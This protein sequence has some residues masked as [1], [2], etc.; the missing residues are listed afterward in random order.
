MTAADGREFDLSLS[1]GRSVVYDITLTVRPGMAVWPQD[2][3]FALQPTLRIDQGGS[4]NVSRLTLS[5]HTGTH[6]DAFL[7]VTDTGSDMASMAL[8]AY[9]GPARVLDTPGDGPI[10]AVRLNT[11]FWEGAERLLFRTRPQGQPAD[12]YAPPFAHFLPDA[13]AEMARAGVRLV[14]LDTPSMDEFHSKTLASH[15]ALVRHGIAILENL[16]LAAVPPGDYELI[17]LPLKLAGADGSPVRAILR[18][19]PPS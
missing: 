16:D 4:C 17:A 8:E 7:H 12:P 14:G 18:K 1:T 19:D 5:P 15:Q 11:L 13:V 6:A 9:L 3:A 10:D 2:T